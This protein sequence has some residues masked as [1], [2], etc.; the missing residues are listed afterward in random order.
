MKS[1]PVTIFA[2]AAAI[3]Y[4]GSA[5][6]LTV[7]ISEVAEAEFRA[8]TATSAGYLSLQVGD[9]LHPATIGSGP[10]PELLGGSNPSML[11][12]SAQFDWPVNWMSSYFSVSYTAADRQLSL[13]VRSGDP[14]GR[15]ATASVSMYV[16]GAF[17]ELYY[18]GTTLVNA[19]Y[20]HPMQLNGA[21]IASLS[22][23]AYGYSPTAHFHGYRVGGS[24]LQSD[25]FLTGSIYFDGG[26][27]GGN[28]NRVEF[29]LGQSNLV[30]EPS[31][32]LLVA[33]GLVALY[34]RRSAA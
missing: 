30:P 27:Q 31:S 12:T 26:T 19:L 15:P 18:G 33:V 34:L 17:D 16:G 9:S 2:I 14:N 3:L 28:T 24:L 23:N 11:T 13:F 4:P 6:A 7:S 8:A 32:G 20:A 1:I 29:G 10:E 22:P 5:F 21:T 25:F